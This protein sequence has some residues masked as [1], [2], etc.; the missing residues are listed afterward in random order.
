MVGRDSE[1]VLRFEATFNITWIEIFLAKEKD[2]VKLH[3]YPNKARIDMFFPTLSQPS[4]T[5]V[6]R[7]TRGGPGRHSV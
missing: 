1:D 7:F 2:L 3:D 4:M 6:T 5:S